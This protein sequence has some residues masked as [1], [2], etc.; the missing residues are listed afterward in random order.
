MCSFEVKVSGLFLATRVEEQND[1]ARHWI[2][3][4]EIGSFLF[5]AAM[6]S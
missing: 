6:A 3:G 2:T 4:R 5:I 1:L